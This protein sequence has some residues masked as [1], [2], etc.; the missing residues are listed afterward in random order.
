[1]SSPVIIGAVGS[2]SGGAGPMFS[3]APV[4]QEQ[5][6]PAL[7]ASQIDRIRPFGRIRQTTVGEILF[8][9]GDAGAH[10]FVLLSGALEIVQLTVQGERTVSPDAHGA[11]SM[12]M[13]NMTDIAARGIAG[14]GIQVAAGGMEPGVLDDRGQLQRRS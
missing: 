8:E 13:P 1:M 14:A 12:Q 7:T 5:A 3:S 6:F 9:P 4:N 2:S 11:Q 10:F